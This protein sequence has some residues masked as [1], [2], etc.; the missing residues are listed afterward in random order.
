MILRTTLDLLGRLAGRIHRPRWTGLALALVSV[1]ALAAAQG[2][3][4]RPGSLLLFPEYD[5]R[6]GFDWLFTVTNTNEDVLGGHVLVEFVYVNADTCYEFNRTEPLTPGDTLT[7]RSAFHN[8][9]INR[10]YLY[11]FARHPTT[12]VPISF[13]HLVGHSIAIDGITQFE[14][15]LNP[16]A[17][18]AIGPQGAPTNLDGDNLRDL[19]G[20]E[21]E[22]V[23]DRILIPRFL[24][25][26]TPQYPLDSSL[27]LIGLSGGSAFSTS[28]Y[29]QTFNDNE[30]TFSTT[31]T[32]FC[33][34]KV[35]LA[36]ISPIF[37]D[38][39][40][41]NFSTHDPLEIAGLN[42]LESGWFWMDGISATSPTSTIPDPA[43]VGV[44][45]ERGGYQAA[46]D[47]PFGEGLQSNGDLL[48]HETLV[49]P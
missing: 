6:P 5:N 22:Q 17:Y 4:P 31:R 29:F 24:G 35:R 45:I 12:G 8:A 15:S 27:I 40:L 14:Y 47:L 48:S 30:E 34:E 11:V 9:G 38:F 16:L 18:R 13:N 10:G 46:S 28:V 21:Y 36:D 41:K 20:L 3:T 7:L 19:D 49:D 43:F 32:F 39:F 26:E 1:S 33:W 2:S 37:T 23:A 25:Q 44:L 42:T